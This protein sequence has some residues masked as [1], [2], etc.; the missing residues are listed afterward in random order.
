[1]SRIC[2]LGTHS[3]FD[4]SFEKKVAAMM[5]LWPTLAELAEG[6]GDAVFRMRVVELRDRLVQVMVGGM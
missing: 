1:M 6:A 2:I 5:V 3:I 4:F